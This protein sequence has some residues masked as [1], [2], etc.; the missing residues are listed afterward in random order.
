MTPII[1]TDFKWHTHTHTHTHTHHTHTHTH[2][3]DFLHGFHAD[4]C[5]IRSSS[6]PTVFI[7]GHCWW[8]SAY[9]RCCRSTFSAVINKWFAYTHTHTPTH[10]HTHTVQ[11][12]MLLSIQS[13]HTHTH[14]HTLTQCCYCWFYY[15]GCIDSHI[16][17]HTGRGFT[18]IY[19]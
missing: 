3:F 15:N 7:L 9:L 19:R 1:T 6:L 5:L 16:G 17:P 14:T 2:T 12:S 4:S 8:Y 18:A 10:T 11:L 13:T